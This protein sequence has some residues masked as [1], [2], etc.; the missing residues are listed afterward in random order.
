MN[1]PKPQAAE[2]GRRERE[3]YCFESL[4]APPS[5]SEGDT[6]LALARQ[7]SD[8][9]SRREFSNNFE[10]SRGSTRHD[11]IS[12]GKLETRREP[13]INWSRFLRISYP[14]HGASFSPF[15]F[16]FKYEFCDRLRDSLWLSNIVGKR[17]LTFG[18]K[19]RY[20]RDGLCIR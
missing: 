1:G 5:A 20:F 15:F 8:G 12:A 13:R 7:A 6:R 9:H 11:H 2:P 4:P 17:S 10:R 18:L 14:V 3:T 16:F 19:F